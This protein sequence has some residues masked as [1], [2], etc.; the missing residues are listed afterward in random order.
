MPRRA[1]PARAGQWMWI[2]IVVGVALMV[3]GVSGAGGW[4]PE[5]AASLG[6]TFAVTGTPDEGGSSFSLSLLWPVAERVSFGAMI[7]GDDA[8]S[9]VDSLRNAQGAGLAYG[10]IEQVHRTAWGASWRLD[11]A[12]PSWGGLTPFASGTWGLYQVRDDLHGTK[13]ADSGSGGYSVGGGLRQRVGGHLS[14]AALV[15]YHRLFNDYE[16]RFMSAGLE[17][18]WR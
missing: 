1:E 11:V 4:R 15:R 18:S 2:W 3:P 17:G 6:G 16:G 10:K 14:L 8:G 7:S 13:V 5:L 12:G 9:S